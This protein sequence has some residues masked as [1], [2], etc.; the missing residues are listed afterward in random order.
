M[1]ERIA[2][3]QSNKRGRQENKETETSPNTPLEILLMGI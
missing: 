2:L 1:T 3:D